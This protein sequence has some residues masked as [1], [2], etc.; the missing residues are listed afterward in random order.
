MAEQFPTEPTTDGLD[1]VTG[2]ATSAGHG[3]PWWQPYLP[4]A[5]VSCVLLAIGFVVVF[6]VADLI[7]ST[8]STPGRDSSNPVATT[9]V[10]PSDNKTPENLDGLASAD[11]SAV[12]AAKLAKLRADEERAIRSAKL[13]QFTTARAQTEKELS[14]LALEMESWAKQL[15]NLLDG[16]GGQRIASDTTYIERFLPVY[17]SNH[18]SQEEFESYQR[19]FMTLSGPIATAE[20]TGKDSNYL[21]SESLL[22]DLRTLQEEV[23]LGIKSFEVS[24]EDAESLQ[25][26][27]ASRSPSEKTLR[28]AIGEF[29]QQRQDAR[30]ERISRRVARRKKKPRRDWLEKRPNKSN[31]AETWSSPA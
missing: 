13:E 24:R 20:K 27:A 8:P 15:K 29:L 30:L 16:D 2:P 3:R 19:R 4:L 9:P 22:I 14:H 18:I 17:E 23:S 31:Y 5:I 28:T 1:D 10:N 25:R 7:F 12:D 21:P 11:S 26:F 6:L